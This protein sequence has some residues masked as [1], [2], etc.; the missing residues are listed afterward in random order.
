MLVVL[1]EIN[2]LGVLHNMGVYPDMFFTDFELFKNRTAM[3]ENADVIFIIAGSCQFNKHVIIDK[4]KELM[5]REV[6]DK[7][8]GIN[9]VNVV[10]DVN[11]PNLRRYFKFVGNINDLTE[12]CGWKNKGKVHFW[13]AYKS[14]KRKDITQENGIYLSSFDTGLSDE[15]RKEYRE[16][17]YHKY[18][19]KEDKDKDTEDEHL[20]D[21]DD[22]YCKLIYKPA[23]HQY[24]SRR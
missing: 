3:F 10:T 17:S 5:K 6:N 4:V 7:D 23:E 11:I 9:S 21:K 24:M 15:L 14:Q 1:S 12:F 18:S 20:G 16:K 22:T 8:T 2:C 13:D 19:D